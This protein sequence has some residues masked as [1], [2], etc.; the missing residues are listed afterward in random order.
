MRHAAQHWVGRVAAAAALL[1]VSVYYLLASIPFAR[2]HFLEFAHFWWL[3]IFVRYHPIVMA[4]G[5]ALALSTSAAIPRPWTRRFA[6]A[7]GLS[8]VWMAVT[9][10]QPVF[11]TYE[12]ATIMASVPLA[13]AA[14]VAILDL[15][16][17]AGA[18]ERLISNADRPRA[19]FEIAAIGGLIAS[20]L[21]LT[22]GLG[23]VRGTVDRLHPSE[24]AIAAAASLAGHAAIFLAPVAAFALLHWIARRGGWPIAARWAAG[25]ACYVLVGAFLVRRIAFSALLMTDRYA[26]AMSITFALAIV[27]WWQALV[28]HRAPAADLAPAGGSGRRWIVAACFMVIVGCVVVLPRLLLLA[29]WGGVLQKSLVLITWVVCAKLV[30]LLTGGARVRAFLAG[31]P[32]FAVA[33][34]LTATAMET[35]PGR[36]AIEDAADVRIALERY[37]SVDRSLATV[38]DVFRPALNDRGFFLALREAADATDKR[39]LAAVP[40]RLIADQLA[41]PPQRPHVFVI[42]VDSLRPDYLGAYRPAGVSFTPAFDAFARESVVMRRAF[43]QYAGTALSQPA[44]WA[45]GLIPRFNYVQPFDAVNNLARLLSAGGYRQ[46]VSMDEISK[47]TLGQLPVHNLSPALLHPERK[48]EMFKFDLCETLEEVTSQLDRDARD[49]RPIFVFTQPQNLHIRVLAEGFPT[50]DGVRVGDREF[51]RPAVSALRRLDSCFGRFIGDLKA[52][53]LYED[54]IVVVTSDHGDSLGEQGRWGHAFY[55]V[56]ETIRIPLLI[57]LPEGLRRDRR[58]DQEAL[59][60]ATDITPSLYN[61]LGYRPSVT[62]LVGRA[63]FPRAEDGDTPARRRYLVQS[64]YTRALGLLIDDGATLYVADANHVT[65]ALFDLRNGKSGEIPLRATER[66][67]YRQWLLDAIA[68]LN[69]F[70]VRG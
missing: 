60:F 13:L 64:S 10:W 5:L 41:P 16:W 11:A 42:V 38:L 1:S 24:L 66:V 36:A 68:E 43:T 52:R 69:A 32:A 45:G 25:V 48:E 9:V 30:A 4:A 21:H 53:H 3:P 46:Y 59:A 8:A 17:T 65:E 55:L 6:L 57:H 12:N 39:S 18:L 20:A 15:R 27:L 40:L 58:I 19:R 28:A 7:G 23:A 54:S 26:L 34:S 31:V 50:Y 70:Y 56:P 62:P 35:T 44:I 22:M 51:F 37:A 63:L 47:L 14:A 49:P 33:A 29:D 2:Y 61:L 67:R